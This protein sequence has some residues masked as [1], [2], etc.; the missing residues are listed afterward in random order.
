MIQGSQVYT[1][2]FVGP[3]AGTQ[4]IKAPRYTSSFMSASADA[5]ET[6]VPGKVRVYEGQSEGIFKQ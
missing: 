2:H 3:D 6:I 1:S 4:M 5:Q